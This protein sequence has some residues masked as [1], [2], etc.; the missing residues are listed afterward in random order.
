MAWNVGV[1]RAAAAAYLDAGDTA[2]ALDMEVRVAI[3]PRTAPGTADSLAADGR[4]RLG[5]GWDSAAAAA[6]RELHASLLERSTVRQ[7]RGVARVEGSDG[8]RHTLRDLLG[9]R[10]GAVIFWTRH[11][12]AAIQALP[13]IVVVAGRLKAAGTPMVLVVD[14]SPSSGVDAY[15][16]ERHWTLPIYHDVK[17]STT[18][19]F[20]NFGTPAYYVLDGAGRIRFDW[21]N[22]EAELIAQVEA[23]SRDEGATAR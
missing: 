16:E 17:G 10:P 7:L 14:E 22:G 3:D 15:L 9:H 18:T 19:A 5:V 4:S 8:E 1:F 20:A 13:N 23:V 2:A 21:V 6:R 11:C 12:G